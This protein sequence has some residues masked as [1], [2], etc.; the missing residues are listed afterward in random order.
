MNA[1]ESMSIME[2][3]EVLAE[4]NGKLPRTCAPELRI[5]RLERTL[6]A[7]T[8]VVVHQAHLIE[9]VKNATMHSFDAV[10][11]QFKGFADLIIA[12]NNLVI[13]ALDSLSEASPET[14]TPGTDPDSKASPA[15]RIVEHKGERF[16]LSFPNDD[17]CIVNEQGLYGFLLP[18]RSSLSAESLVLYLDD[19]CMAFY[20]DDMVS[21]DLSDV[22]L[23]TTASFRLGDMFATIEN[24]ARIEFPDVWN[25]DM[26]G[27]LRHWWDS[28][29]EGY[30]V[31][32]KQEY[33]EVEK[34]LLH[35][36]ARILCN[37][38]LANGMKDVIE[39][40]L[41]QR[42]LQ[43]VGALPVPESL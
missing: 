18:S 38:G 39:A 33:P 37:I 16:L 21:D 22:F 31:F 7:L 26:E 23:D 34:V 30:V 32:S 9:R 6:S 28:D 12:N 42:F 36:M 41:V 40:Q 4:F 20:G 27:S 1:H 35:A 43:S 15:R 5:G 8:T 24:A 11:T 25:D 19:L 14:S 10:D 3:T 17:P 29:L 2:L 13:E